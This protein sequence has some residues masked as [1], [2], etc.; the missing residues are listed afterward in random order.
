[1]SFTP[2][3]GFAPPTK[4]SFTTTPNRREEKGVEKDIFH[5]A[6]MFKKL[7]EET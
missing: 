4:S 6:R 1:M 3:G 2:N 7:H 5:Q